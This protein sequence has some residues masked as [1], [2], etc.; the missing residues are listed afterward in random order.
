MLLDILLAWSQIYG[1]E[2][3]DHSIDPG[4]KMNLATRVQF[5]K[6]KLHLNELLREKLND[7]KNDKNAKIS[8]STERKCY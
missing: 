8:M 2:L 5:A 3:Y 4:E 7:P 6:Q 1:E